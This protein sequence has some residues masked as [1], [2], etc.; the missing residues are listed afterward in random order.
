MVLFCVDYIMET[1]I[2][3]EKVL[4]V[5]KHHFTLNSKLCYKLCIAVGLTWKEFVNAPE[6]CANLIIKGTSRKNYRSMKR[7]KRKR[8]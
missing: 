4:N 7:G 2:M 8:G 3:L 5:S 1:Y 6:V